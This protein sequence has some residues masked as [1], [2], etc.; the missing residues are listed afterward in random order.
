MS[1]ETPVKIRLLQRKLYLKAKADTTCR[2]NRLYG[3]ISVRMSWPMRTNGRRPIKCVPGLDGQTFGE[4]KRKG[5]RSGR[6]VYG[7]NFAPRSYEP[8]PV[9]RVM[10]PKPGAARGHGESRPSGIG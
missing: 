3:K 2:F 7:V 1:L 6:R 10:I 9:R 8:L 4:S 5:W